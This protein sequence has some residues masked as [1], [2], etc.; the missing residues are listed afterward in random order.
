MT[1]IIFLMPFFAIAWFIFFITK[2]QLNNILTGLIFVSYLFFATNY[3]N[4]GLEIDIFRY[5]HRFIGVI[6][7][8]FL[9]I[10]IVRF[11]VNLFKEKVPIIMASFLLVLLC[12][13]VGNDIYFEYYFHYVR[14]F[15]FISAVALYLYFYIDSNEK[16][17][18]IFSLIVSL[19]LILVFFA[20][21]DVLTMGFSN[22]RVTLVFSNPNYLGIALMPG[23][24]LSLFS[25]KKI[26]LFSSIFI[27]IAIL[28]TESSAA[29]ISAVF[30]IFIYLFSKT[31]KKILLVP[32]LICIA[33]LLN[34]LPYTAESIKSKML[35]RISLAAISL[36]IFE[37]HPLNGIGYGQFRKNF[38]NYIDL[39]V[40]KL[41]SLEINNAY[42]ANNPTSPFLETGIYKDL[43]PVDKD[44]IV[45]GY[46]E[47]MT[48][49]D[50]LTII[51]E[52][53]L[54]GLSFLVFLFYKLYAELKK[55]LFY[56]KTNF[57]KVA[58]L[59]ATSLI[60]SLFHNN[61]TSFMF[62]FLIIIPFLM[63]RNYKNYLNL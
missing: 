49:S 42:L 17:D 4:F 46:K 55:L 20:F 61:M 28:L 41:N 16:L 1:N 14:N 43:N 47:K 13:Y 21:I 11:K 44:S 58:L 22:R 63:N 15:I 62:W 25:E 12:S 54:I 27:F 9:L 6:A 10:H 35:S 38:H 59:I 50:L 51:A 7:I 40:F 26:L 53:G 23:L 57:Y 45:Y 52:L 3:E 5:L 31:F 19:T 30:A 36:N 48:H 24:I 8:L 34:S 29:I 18:E 60:F 33:L 2:N 39:D 56:N 37:Q 32:F